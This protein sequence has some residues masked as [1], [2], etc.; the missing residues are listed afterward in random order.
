MEWCGLKNFPDCQA[1]DIGPLQPHNILKQNRLH[2]KNNALRLPIAIPANF[3][4]APDRFFWI[5]FI[6]THEVHL[7]IRSHSERFEK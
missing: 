4:R 5:L 6:D 3:F 2:L 7:T 1:L